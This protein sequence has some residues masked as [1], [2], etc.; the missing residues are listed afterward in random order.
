MWG[1]IMYEGKQLDGQNTSPKGDA[2][3]DLRLAV[4]EAANGDKRHLGTVTFKK[5]EDVAWSVELAGPRQESIAQL[6]AFIQRLIESRRTIAENTTVPSVTSPADAL[7]D[8][9]TAEGFIVEKLPAGDWQVN[10]QID[11]TTGKIVGTHSA[12][13]PLAAADISLG[14]RLFEAIA[15]S[16]SNFADELSDELTKSLAENDLN[17]AVAAI[18][19]GLEQGLFGLRLSDRLLNLLLRIDVTNLSDQDKRTVR[20]GRL[21][22]AQQ[23]RR[24]DVAG[25][26]AD[27]ILAEDKGTFTPEQIA[28]LKLTGA[29]GALARGNRETALATIHNLLKEPS[30]LDAEAR[31]WAQ[32]NIAFVLPDNDPEALLAAQYSADAF[33]EAGNKTEASISL[34]RVA[35][36]LLHHEPREAV[37]KL[38]DMIGILD[39][40][41]LNARHIRGAAFHARANRFSQINQHADA[42][43]DA[44]QAVEL[45][46]GLLGAESQL[47]SSL[48]L[49]SVEARTI[50]QTDKAGAFAAE[51]AKLT[52]D[53]KHPHF[54]LA[55]RV[56]ALAN[57]FDAK[58]AEELRR[59]AEAAN[60]MEVVGCISVLQAKLDPSLT[61]MQRLERLEETNTRLLAARVR[62]QALHPVTLAIAKQL[63][64]MAEPRRAVEWYMKIIGSNPYDNAV[65]VELVNTLWKMKEWGEAAMFI[66]KQLKL[67]GEHPVMLFAYGRS[68]LESGEF[69]GAVSALSRA[70]ALGEDNE[71]FKAQATELRDRALELGG[72]LLPPPPP[73][74]A[75]GPV[76]TD[77]F[78]EALTAFGKAVSVMHR[79]DF[80]SNEKRGKRDWAER[81]E[82]RAQAY[83][84]I[85]LQA[86]FGE[87][88]DLFKEIGAG[89]G[90]LDIYVKFVGG[91]SIVIEIKMCGGRYSSRYAAEGEEQITHYLENTGTK[92]GYLIIFD[93]RRRKFRETVLADDRTPYMVFEEFVDVR[94]DVKLSNPVKRPKRGRN[95]ARR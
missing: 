83:L 31:G 80:W 8:M 32:R 88:V 5:A 86:K 25:I 33:L 79:M 46:R 36:I 20:D 21:I 10:F 26:E 95:K 30:H 11:L 59:D 66:K 19:S 7:T 55:E 84:L 51:A 87:R 17:G 71:T 90:R 1:R 69:S 3:P 18:K 9:L 72:T 75:T 39:N 63:V 24:F 89:A 77:E 28:G 61:N 37:K 13:H 27:H 2:P 16:L 38:N 45:Q 57:R 47:I 22:T 53:L 62:E 68:L 67:R 54:Q 65:S 12:M 91:P 52:E 50:G 58:S 42:F 41:G 78:K 14:H 85:Y 56:V 92:L 49:A 76:T 15:R 43:R 44:V 73:K 70:L 60:N 34:M 48:H 94:P 93:S 82:R 23:M 40:E 35:D 6:Q 4:F 81:P 29:V 64:A 74:P